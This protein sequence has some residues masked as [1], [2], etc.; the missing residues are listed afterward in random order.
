M[1]PDYLLE[2]RN[3]ITK[4]LEGNIPQIMATLFASY[5]NITAQSVI[6]QNN[7]L[8]NYVY[9]VT[10]PI[11]KVFNMAQEFQK[12]SSAYGSEQTNLQIITLVYNVLRKT[13]R[14]TNDLIDWNRKLDQDKTWEEFKRHF[15][16]PPVRLVSRRK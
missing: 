4:K 3:S 15:R 9:D 11:D 6:E 16:E 13:G 7:L 1:N 10:M 8:M 14:F 5:A 2:I 12:Y